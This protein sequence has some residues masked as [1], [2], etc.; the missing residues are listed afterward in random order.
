VKKKKKKKNHNKGFGPRFLL[1]PSASWPTLM[2][3]WVA[4]HGAPRP[5]FL[6]TVSHKLSFQRHRYLL[7]LASLK[8]NENK[9]PGIF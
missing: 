7:M 3:P 2:L 1:A 9:M 6:G 5:L 4:L 8:L